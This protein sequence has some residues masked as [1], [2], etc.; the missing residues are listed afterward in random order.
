MLNLKE[1][2]MAV[3]NLTDDPCRRC[4]GRIILSDV[5]RDMTGVL[6]MAK[7]FPRGRHHHNGRV[8]TKQLRVRART[9]SEFCLAVIGGGEV[10]SGGRCPYRA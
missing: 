7:T 5:H 2:T 6:T 8:D 4:R 3:G 9:S 1:D 10:V